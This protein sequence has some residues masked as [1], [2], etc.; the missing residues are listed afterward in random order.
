MQPVEYVEGEK[1]RHHILNWSERCI[2]IV[3]SALYKGRQTEALINNNEK[4]INM[5]VLRPS[6]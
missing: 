5:H 1:K 4:V 6:Q 2:L 3:Y